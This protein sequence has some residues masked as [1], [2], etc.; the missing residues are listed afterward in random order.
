MQLIMRKM[1]LAGNT[2]LVAADEDT[3][4]AVQKMRE[5]EVVTFK[6]IRNPANLRRYFVFIRESFDM[7]DKFNNI[8]VWRKYLQC[9]AG[10]YDEVIGENGKVYYFPRSIDYGS[11]D[12]LEF[13]KLFG[14]VVQAFLDEF[15]TKI[16]QEQLD[17]IVRF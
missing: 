13:K 5:M 14:E 16:T 4:Y 3:A 9:G 12:E 2:A 7:Q 1:F 17:I 11:L 15:G 8:S 10:H 6:R